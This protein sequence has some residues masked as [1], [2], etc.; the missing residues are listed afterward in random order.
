MVAG[1]ALLGALGALSILPPYVG[2]PL[3]LELDVAKDVEV[4]DHVVP[5]VIIVLCSVGAALMLRAQ[6]IGTD[7]LALAAA[8]GVS[9]LAGV[10]ETSS[11]VPLLLDGGGPQT[12]WGTVIFH[13]V[14]GPVVAGM[15]L[16]LLLRVFDAEPAP[17]RAPRARS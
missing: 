4:V 11:H 14:L 16:V 13:S 10:W 9:L 15:A 1:L 6:R 7:S 3:G 8:V 12:P 5:G 2:P 17:D